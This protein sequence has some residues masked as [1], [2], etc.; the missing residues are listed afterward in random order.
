[1]H[2]GINNITN[3]S[4]VKRVFASLIKFMQDIKHKHGLTMVAYNPNLCQGKSLDRQK[5]YY[6]YHD[7]LFV[8]K[9]LNDK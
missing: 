1:M 4:E 2:T 9:V 3:K 7:L 8:K 6:P 5:T